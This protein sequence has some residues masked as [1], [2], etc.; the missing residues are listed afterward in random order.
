M[1]KYNLFLLF[2]GLR[3]T[4]ESER[5]LSTVTFIIDLLIS[6]SDLPYHF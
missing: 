5:K 1:I 4:A 6:I 3:E 2:F